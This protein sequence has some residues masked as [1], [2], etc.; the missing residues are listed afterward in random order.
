M[1]ASSSRRTQRKSEPSRAVA[2]EGLAILARETA[3]QAEMLHI[4]DPEDPPNKTKR[5]DRRRISI[6]P[7]RKSTRK[8]GS[9]DEAPQSASTPEPEQAG[10][11][12]QVKHRKPAETTAPAKIRA[13]S[14]KRARSEEHTSELQS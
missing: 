3:R 6:N 5:T 11:Q 4:D 13:K 7:P 8:Q 12:K 10:Y 2:E 9:P 14:A 1:S